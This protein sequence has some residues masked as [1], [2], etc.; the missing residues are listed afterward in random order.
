MVFLINHLFFGG[1]TAFA[2]PLFTFFF[3]LIKILFIYYFFLITR[4]AIPR[5][6]YDQLMRLGWKFVLP[7]TLMM[8]FLLSLVVIFML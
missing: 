5:Y 6:R 1:W 8:F 7:L 3:Y 2:S 4:A